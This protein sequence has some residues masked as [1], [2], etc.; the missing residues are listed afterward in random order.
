MLRKRNIHLPR[1]YSPQVV[2]AGKWGKAY[3]SDSNS[4]DPG[5]STIFRH[6]LLG[7]LFS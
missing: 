6:A 2:D 5:N 3:S 7:E 1:S 4:T